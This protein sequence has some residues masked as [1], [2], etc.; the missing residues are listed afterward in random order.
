MC[1]PCREISI[2]R[3]VRDAM[4]AFGRAA[5]E[6]VQE[7]ADILAQYQLTDSRI[8]RKLQPVK[9]AS[10]QEMP[11]EKERKKL[12]RRLEGSEEERTVWCAVHDG[13]ETVDAIVEKTGL[14]GR[15]RADGTDNA[16]SRAICRRDRERVSGGSRC[17]TI[18]SN[19]H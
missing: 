7:P 10:I 3:P 13:Q 9:Q 14:P 1:S 4:H 12:L 18:E 8:Q 6:L 17:R 2:G 15:Q 11:R 19:H 5:A 16:G